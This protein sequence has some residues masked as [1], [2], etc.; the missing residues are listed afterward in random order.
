MSETMTMDA[1]HGAAGLPV[2]A[3]DGDKIGSV[4]EI[5]YDD[6]TGT[7]EWVGVGTG[8]LGTKRVLVPVARA[9]LN[10]DAL[11]V[12]YAKEHVKDSPDVDGDEIGQD[13]ERELYA[14]YGLEYSERRSDSGLPDGGVGGA[15]STEGAL[16]TGLDVS[17]DSAGDT[18]EGPP[19]VTRT[20]EELR[21]GT[22]SVEA[23]RARLRKWV[24]T[25]PVQAEVEV[26]RE[27]ARVT[28][29][30]VEEPVAGAEIAEEEIEVPLRAEEPVAQKR[31]V[32]KERIG[33]E[34]DVAT[35]RETISDDVRKERVEVEGSVEGGYR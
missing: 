25:E 28:R 6:D 19:A 29:Q 1:L 20:E 24:E 33:L 32:A 4:E 15:G 8:F 34:K 7:P 26:R 14:Y 27:T 17:A 3:S 16:D 23:G 35:D 30:P 5:F 2:L 12:P 21:V 10:G 9:E 11:R 13:T 22:R 18:Y 31:A